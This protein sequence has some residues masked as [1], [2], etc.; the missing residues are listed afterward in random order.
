LFPGNKATL[1]IDGDMTYAAMFDAIAIAKD[2]I[3]FET[4]V[5][6]DDDIGRRFADLLVKKCAQG[7]AVNLIYDAFGCRR[8]PRSFFDRLKEG[9]VNIT[10]FNPVAIGRL[11]GP[12]AFYRRTH[13][14]VLIVDGAVAFTGGI[15]I[16]TAYLRS[17]PPR[18]RTSPPT[19]FWR[20]TDV[21]I[22]GPAVAAFQAIFLRTWLEQRGEEPL[23][24]NYFPQAGNKGDQTVQ[25]VNSTPGYLNRGN[26]VMYVSAVVNAQKSIHIMHS[27]FAPDR[28]MMKA[29]VDAAGR[30][31]DVRIILPEHTDHAIVRQAARRH[32]QELLDGGVRIYE[33]AGALLHSK[34]AVVDGVWSTVGSTNLELW[35]FVTSDEANA[36][37]L[38]HRFAADMEDSFQKDLAQSREILADEWRRR[39]F[40]DRTKEFIS[41]LFH[42]WL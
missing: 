2:H 20:D 13:R 30:G 27:Y 4:Y 9:G 6:E 25:V 36:V 8:T 21:M 23:P 39:S 11:W 1:L 32:Y 38:G 3:N 17:R 24:G 14:K 12:N 34:T 5:I 29:L 10:E 40:L 37:V 33:R 7:V 42:Y 35:S 26:Y 18:D 16:G 31:V 41:D 15:N 19:E 22:E 28:Q